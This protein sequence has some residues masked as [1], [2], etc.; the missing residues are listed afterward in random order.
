[1]SAANALDSWVCQCCLTDAA[2]INDTD[3]EDE[4]EF[5]L[6]RAREWTVDHHVVLLQEMIAS[7]WF[8]FKKGGVARGERW[9][10]ITEKL[11]QVKAPTFHVKDK[12]AKIYTLL[13][14]PLMVCTQFHLERKCLFSFRDTLIE[15]LVAKEDIFSKLKEDQSKKQ[16]EG[17]RKAEDKRHKALEQYSETKKGKSTQNGDECEE[18]PKRKR[19]SA[20]TKPLIEFM[21]ERAKTEQDLQQQEIDL[22]RV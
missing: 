22:R 18:K 17:K 10:A 4:L 12:R 21:Q 13:G 20:R 3:T 8:T 2:N 19:R 5:N 16:K 14:L 9:K 15:E 11:N 6:L 7:Y 1:M